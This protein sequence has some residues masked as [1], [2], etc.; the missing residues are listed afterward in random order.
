[1]EAEHC[2]KDLKEAKVRLEALEKRVEGGASY[3]SYNSYN[4]YGELVSA[5]G[6]TRRCDG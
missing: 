6:V 4:S 1:M 2:E 3:N 5:V